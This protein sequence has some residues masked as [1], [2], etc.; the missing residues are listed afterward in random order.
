MAA[1]IDRWTQGWEAA[2]LDTWVVRLRSHPRVIGYGGCSVLGGKVWNLGYRMA[3]EAQGHGYATE[4]AREAM[5]HAHLSSPVLPVV[6]YLLEHNLASERVALKVGMKRVHRGPD[7][8][9]PDPSATRLVYADRAL[10]A[11]ELAATLR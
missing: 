3:S 8:G 9:N 11:D 6:A 10:S 4:V 2:G 1:M 5:G 7:A